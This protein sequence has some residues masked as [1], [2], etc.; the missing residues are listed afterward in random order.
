[1]DHPALTVMATG[2]YPSQARLGPLRSRRRARR[3]G[4]F[5]PRRSL[6][7]GVRRARTGGPKTALA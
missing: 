1:V 4:D 3:S 7:L 6:T 5:R 2:L